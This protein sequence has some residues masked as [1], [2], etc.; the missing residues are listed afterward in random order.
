MDSKLKA[1]C[2][3]L[4]RKGT[5]K[6]KPRNEAKKRYR[7]PWGKFKNGNTKY[8]YECAICGEIGP[9]KDIK[10]DHIDPVSPLEGFKLRGDFDLH[11]YAER[12]FCGPENFQA[13]CSV[14]HD[15]KTKEENKI[16]RLNK[17]KLL[18]KE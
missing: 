8:G 7:R 18:T 9:S 1:F 15:K 2:I 6:W 16:R 11:E 10:M 4:L 17:K 3:N 13:T 5:F 12:M 14:C